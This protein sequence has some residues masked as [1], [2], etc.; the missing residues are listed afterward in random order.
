MGEV[1]YGLTDRQIQAVS[2]YYYDCLTLRQIGD[3]MGISRQAAHGLIQRGR[4]H[5]EAAGHRLSR[6]IPPT[7]KVY[8]C[9]PCELD[10]YYANKTTDAL[11]DD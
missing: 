3:I 1:L 8:Y 9:D 11:Q 5:V 6:Y 10:R 7:P 4:K 2:L